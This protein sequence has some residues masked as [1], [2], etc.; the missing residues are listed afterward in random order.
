MIIHPKFVFIHNPHTGGAFV[1]KALEGLGG[2]FSKKASFMILTDWHKPIEILPKRYWNKLKF[3]VIRNPWEWYASFF[4]HQKPN[5]A[6]IK[7]FT[8]GKNGTYADEKEEFKIF[9]SNMLSRDFIKPHLGTKF[10][11]VGNPYLKPS[12]KKLDYMHALDIGF[13]SYRYIYMF[14]DHY[15]RIFMDENKRKVFNEHDKLLSLDVVLR[16]ENLTEGL[17][18]LFNKR[19][20][21]ITGKGKKFLRK[22]PRENGIRR[23]HYTEYYDD[24]LI[25]LVRKKDRLIIDK[26]NY[27][28]GDSTG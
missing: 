24:N 2:S 3:G 12:V 18:D 27:K 22:H 16:N 26:Y 11:P 21:E 9:L 5:G 14:F 17:I 23:K 13:F 10:H 15:D 1:R 4:A 28:Y 25:E 19:G 8:N 6:F 7:F 20:I